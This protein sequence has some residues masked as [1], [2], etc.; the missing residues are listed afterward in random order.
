M[1]CPDR[2]T[3]VRCLRG[4]EP[5][6]TVLAAM[7]AQ[8]DRQNLPSFLPFSGATTRK[9][10]ILRQVVIGTMVAEINGDNRSQIHVGSIRRRKEKAKP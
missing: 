8:S 5:T 6:K 7:I 4:D 10:L 2:C 1:A 3:V 9:I